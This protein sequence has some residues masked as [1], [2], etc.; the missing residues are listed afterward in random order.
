MMSL[1]PEVARESALL[2]ALCSSSESEPQA[3]GTTG[4][5]RVPKEPMVL[6]MLMARWKAGCLL[7]PAIS[8]KFWVS[9]S[10]MPVCN[11]RSSAAD[12]DATLL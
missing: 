1:S 3:G 7:V 2:L 12:A 4:Q 6:S 5:V 10:D 11:P 8:S 9:S